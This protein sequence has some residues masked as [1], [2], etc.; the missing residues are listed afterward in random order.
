VK[1]PFIAKEVETDLDDIADYIGR[2]N[3]IRALSFVRELRSYF[4]TIAERPN[5]FPKHDK[6]GD[7]LRSAVHGRYHIVFTTIDDRVHILRVI[8][9]ARDINSLFGEY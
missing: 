6:W 4:S 8:H 1:K 5:S 3:P 9:G 2:D 7:D